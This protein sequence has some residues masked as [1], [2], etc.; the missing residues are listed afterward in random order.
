[1]GLPQG[2]GEL[3]DIMAASGQC[4][5]VCLS[6]RGSGCAHLPGMLSLE[7]SLVVL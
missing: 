5:Q 2:M 7:L 4:S 1:M 3:S 6:E